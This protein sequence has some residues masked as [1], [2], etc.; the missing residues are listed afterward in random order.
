MSKPKVQIGEVIFVRKPGNSKFDLLGDKRM[1]A[2][3]AFRAGT[4]PPS[5]EARQWLCYTGEPNW[6][7]ITPDQVEWGNTK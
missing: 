3:R 5:M 7:K 6:P 2:L 1:R 4:L